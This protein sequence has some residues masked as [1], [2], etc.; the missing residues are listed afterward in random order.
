[1]RCL[2]V[3]VE[4]VTAAPDLHDCLMSLA[5]SIASLL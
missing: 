5:A 1:M 4:A 2:L 3:E